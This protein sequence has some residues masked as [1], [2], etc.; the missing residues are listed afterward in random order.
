[1]ILGRGPVGLSNQSRA[2]GGGGVGNK[3][4][5]ERTARARAGR[6]KEGKENSYQEGR[7]GLRVG[8]A[9]G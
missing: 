8:R 1:M 7:V 4:S 2:M 3:D 5:G 6:T 9:T